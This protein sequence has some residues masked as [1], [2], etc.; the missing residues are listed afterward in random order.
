VLAHRKRLPGNY[1]W[2]R[3]WPE[4]QHLFAAFPAGS[5]THWHK[6]HWP[7]TAHLLV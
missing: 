2:P 7:T 6:V 5:F 3:P 1:A 4:T